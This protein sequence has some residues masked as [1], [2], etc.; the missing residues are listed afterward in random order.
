M[1]KFKACEKE[2]KT[3]AYSK[4]GLSQ[5]TK[6]DPKEKEKADTC[7]WVSEMVE[8][9]ALQIEAAEAEI[10]TLQSVA[11]KGRRDNSKNERASELEHTVERHKWHT[12]RLELILRLLQNGNIPPEKV[13]L[14]S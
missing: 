9:L 4:E 14:Y 10:E 5:M 11:K 7:N 2:M 8:Q 1:E 13:C 3:K 12:N 6:M